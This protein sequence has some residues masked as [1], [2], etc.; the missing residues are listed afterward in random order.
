MLPQLRRHTIRGVGT[1]TASH[2]MV[3]MPPSSTSISA[4]GGTVMIGAAETYG[5]H[6]LLSGE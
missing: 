2:T 5:V 6:T 1:P 4:T 3:N